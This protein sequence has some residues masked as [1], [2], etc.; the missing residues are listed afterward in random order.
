MTDAPVLVEIRDDHIAVISLNRPDKLNALNAEVRGVLMETF[1][2]LAEDDAVRAVVIHGMGE[3][4]FVAGADITEFAAR[5]ADE[6][7][8]VYRTK[9]IYEAVADFP[10]PVIA[11]IHGFCIGGGSEL[12]LACDIRVADSTTRISQAEIRIG[13]IPGG[14]GTQRLARLVGRGWASI[15]SFTGDFIEADEA[16]RIGLIDVLVDEGTHLER[17]IELAGRMT[18]WSPVSLRLAKDAIR[19]AFEL[20]LADGLVYEMERFLD[21]FASDDGREGVA[22]FVAKRK[23]NFTGR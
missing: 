12:A 3:K 6:Q 21:A 14:G 19:A 8:A 15:I 10:K 17:A 20:P 18:R 2:A 11:A 4:A 16:H 5:T 7:R 23:P 22:A 9:R 13:L 1:D